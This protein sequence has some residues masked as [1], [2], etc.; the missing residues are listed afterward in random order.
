MTPVTHAWRRLAT[1]IDGIPDG[2]WG[3]V[4][5]AASFSVHVVILGLQYS[6]GVLYA[7]LLSD[8]ALGGDRASTAWVGSIAVSAMLGM[9]VLTGVLVERYGHRVVTCAGGVLCA[10]GLLLSSCMPSVHALY[11]TY[12]CIV[13]I[14][15]NLSFAP[16]VMIVS[17]Y[18][19]KRRSLATGIAVS[20]S[21]IGTLI[22][23]VMDE[24]LIRAYGWRVCLQVSAV[25]ALVIVLP[26]GLTYIPVRVAPPAAP[27]PA[28]YDPSPTTAASPATVPTDEQLLKGGGGATVDT[29]QLVPDEQAAAVPVSIAPAPPT[30]QSTL[31]APQPIAAQARALGPKSRVWMSRRYQLFAIAICIFAGMLFVPYTHLVTFA[32]EEAWLPPT[33]AASIVSVIGI[34]NMAGRIIFGR[35][36]DIPSIPKLSVFRANILASGAAVA[37][38]SMAGTQRWYL[39]TFALIFGLNSG[40][41]VSL[42]PPILAEMM[43]LDLLPHAL[44]GMYSVQAPSV[45]LGP[46]IAGWIRAAA[47]QYQVAWLLSGACMMAAGLVLF[48]VRGRVTTALP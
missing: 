6:F 18:F 40:S 26:A 34:A 8:A 16:S 21:G 11:V 5:V 27:P 29:E 43:G 39:Y 24:A 46:P 22:F 3:W 7:A 41:I 35:L 45:L 31:P 4:V 38:L 13:G 48:A 33:E 14:G 2:G 17:R 15:F 19:D 25:L 36:A 23:A 1:P 10:A 32:V 28:N 37:A 42:A 30:L 12:G 47:G 20:G 9:G 44:G